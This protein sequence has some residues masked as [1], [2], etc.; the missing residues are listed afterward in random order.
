MTAG[1]SRSGGVDVM[2]WCSSLNISLRDIRAGVFATMVCSAAG[3]ADGIADPRAPSPDGHAVDGF[4]EREAVDTQKADS[5]PRHVRSSEPRILA[6]IDAGLSGSP[7]FRSLVAALDASDVIVYIDAKVTRPNQGGYL[8]HQIVARG[9]YRYLRV[10]VETRGSD[11]RL[12]PLLAHE[13][14][15]AIEVAQTPEAVDAESL[16]QLFDRLSVRFGCDGTTCSETQAARDIE[17]VVGKELR[18][19]RRAPF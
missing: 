10:A 14:Q 5:S 7:T 19:A 4:S 1:L 11:T 12:I 16:R 3:T 6:L 18:A 9:G 17:Y 15:H 8:A 13:L 2:T